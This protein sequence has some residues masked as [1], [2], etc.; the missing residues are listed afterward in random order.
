MVRSDWHPPLPKSLRH[1]SLRIIRTCTGF[2]RKIR[3]W[4]SS[5]GLQNRHEEKLTCLRQQ[6]A[7][8]LTK[9]AVDHGKRDGLSV[10]IEHLLLG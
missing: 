8:V 4:E 1:A 3:R 7:L 5:N 2:G 6:H 9:T 10:G